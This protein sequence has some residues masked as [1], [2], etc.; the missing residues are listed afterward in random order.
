MDKNDIVSLVNQFDIYLSAIKLSRT[1]ES[2]LFWVKELV[3]LGVTSHNNG[4]I[5]IFFFTNDD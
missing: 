5:I 3:E 4:I 2:E 1:V